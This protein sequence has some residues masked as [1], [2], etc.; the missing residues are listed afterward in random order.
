MIKTFSNVD[1]I[2]TCLAVIN[3]D[4]ALKEDGNCYLQV[5]LKECEYFEKNVIRHIRDD[6]MFLSC[7]VRVSE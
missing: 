7:H 3:L 5:F 2:Y 4:S 1:S 6:C